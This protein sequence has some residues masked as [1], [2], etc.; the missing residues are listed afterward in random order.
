[1]ELQLGKLHVC[2]AGSWNVTILVPLDNQN[3]MSPFDRHMSFMNSAD[4]YGASWARVA[5][6]WLTC[7]SIL[8]PCPMVGALET[9]SFSIL[10]C[11][12]HSAWVFEVKTTALSLSF[13]G[14]GC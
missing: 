5:S 3:I 6:V 14:H 11:P 9:A 10:R 1:M 8:I 2:S 7:A 4:I 12:R 13:E